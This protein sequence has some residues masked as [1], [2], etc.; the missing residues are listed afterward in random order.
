MVNILNF[1]PIIHR[2]IFFSFSF[3]VKVFIF[4]LIL[5]SFVQILS[6]NFLNFFSKGEFDSIL[7]LRFY[8]LWLKSDHFFLIHFSKLSILLFSKYSYRLTNPSQ[9][10]LKSMKRPYLCNLFQSSVHHKVSRR[11]HHQIFHRKK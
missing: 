1:K 9:H 8:H 2:T 3:L 6:N 10:K 4:I 7:G 11:F 5:P